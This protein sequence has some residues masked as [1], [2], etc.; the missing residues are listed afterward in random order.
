LCVEI[1]TEAAQ[2]ADWDTFVVLLQTNGVG[3]D[4]VIEVR[5][6]I[7]HQFREL[8]IAYQVG[9]GTLPKSLN[10]LRMGGYIH[11]IGVVSKVRI[12]AVSDT[13]NCS[14]VDSHQGFGR[15]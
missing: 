5:L 12:T 8:Q 9:G 7:F 4:H 15:T 3:V 13:F 14:G 11:L 2:Y 10:S 6:P 1:S